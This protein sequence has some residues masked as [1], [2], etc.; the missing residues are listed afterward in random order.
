MILALPYCLSTDAVGV[1]ESAYSFLHKKVK[2]GSAEYE[3]LPDSAALVFSDH[4]VGLN[5]WV[6]FAVSLPFYSK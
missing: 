6:H 2:L 5:S 1:S 3:N 4:L